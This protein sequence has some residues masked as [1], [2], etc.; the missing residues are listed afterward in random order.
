M[1]WSGSFSQNYVDPQHLIEAEQQIEACH[2]KCIPTKYHEPD[3]N[4]GEQKCIDRCVGKYMSI[5]TL[6]GEKLRHLAPGSDPQND[7]FQ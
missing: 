4:K 7:S 1:S 3:L 6:L 5:Q 2:D